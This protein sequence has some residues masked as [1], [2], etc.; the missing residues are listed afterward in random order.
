MEFWGQKPGKKGTSGVCPQRLSIA[1]GWGRGTGPGRR[2]SAGVVV[3][4]GGAL[5]AEGGGVFGQDPA[6]ADE[7][8][9][10]FFVAREVVVAAS[11]A[12]GDGGAGIAG[13]FAFGC[14]FW[15]GEI[16]AE[17]GDA[18]AGGAGGGRA[19]VPAGVGR[20]GDGDFGEV[21]SGALVAVGIDLRNEDGKGWAD[22]RRL[23]GEDARAAPVGAEVEVPDFVDA[24]GHM[25]VRDRREGELVTGDEGAVGDVGITGGRRGDAVAD[26]GVHVGDHGAPEPADGERRL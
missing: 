9:D 2:M 7:V 21:D 8:V 15:E 26:P 5:F 25:D 23:D 17:E 4:F 11:V 13:G 6:L 3:P 10:G 1:L 16:G 22:V 14:G 24:G 20:E 12:L 18:L 19:E